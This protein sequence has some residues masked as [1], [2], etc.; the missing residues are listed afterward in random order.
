MSTQKQNEYLLLFRGSN[1]DKGLS[2]EQL[3]KSV[4]QFMGWFERLKQEGKVKG[5]QPLEREGKIVSGKNGRVVADGPFAESKE[6]IGGYF[7]L[8]VDD[9]DE[10]VEI[11][12]Q[13]PILEYGSTVEVRPVAEECPTLHRVREQLAE[14]AA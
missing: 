13:C 12:K 7:L 6:A 10:A 11:A 5:G 9:L 8:Q 14:A 1:W 2:P 4:D 3:Q